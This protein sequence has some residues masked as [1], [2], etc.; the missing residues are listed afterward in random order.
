MAT[1]LGPLWLN[2]VQQLAGPTY[3]GRFSRFAV[4][5]DRVNALEPAIEKC[6]DDELK[7]AAHMPCD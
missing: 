4:L 2:Q 3:T 6:T 7:V 5:A 1:R